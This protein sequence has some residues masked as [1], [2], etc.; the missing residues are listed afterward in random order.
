MTITRIIN[1]QPVEIELTRSEMIQAAE[2]IRE[3]DRREYIKN[4]IHELDDDDDRAVLKRL[5]GNALTDAIDGML[6]DFELLVDDH[7]YD[8]DDAWMQVSVDYVDNL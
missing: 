7:D 8:W 6:I 5:E 1:G 3:D 2:A 4:C